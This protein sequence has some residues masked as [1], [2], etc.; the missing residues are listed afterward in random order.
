MKTC[1][2]KKKLEGSR[3]TEYEKPQ[4]HKIVLKGKAQGK[5]QTNAT[6]TDVGTGSSGGGGGTGSGT[7][8]S[9][10]VTLETAT[11]VVVN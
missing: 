4:L 7:G 9:G 10:S 8:G 5:H 6:T 3:E 2:V 11:D 1:D